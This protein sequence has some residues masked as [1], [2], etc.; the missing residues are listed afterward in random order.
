[1]ASLISRLRATYRATQV[2]DFRDI[3]LNDVIED[4]YALTS[5][6][7]RHKS[8]TF[9]F[10]PDPE[11][12]NVLVIPDQIRQVILNLFMNAI[13]A[14]QAGGEFTVCTQSLVKDN[15]VLITFSDT[16]SG[17]NP[18]I[19]PRIFEPFVTDK[20]TGT[21]LGLTITHDIILQHHGDIQA[22]NNSETGATFKVWLPVKRGE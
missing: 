11:L 7:M 1:M 16:G 5:T 3:W 18:E 6:Y 12:P 21:G 2:E 14:M 22:E 15:Q 4:V 20:D 17:I 13:E 10:Q 8:I 9:S 19:L